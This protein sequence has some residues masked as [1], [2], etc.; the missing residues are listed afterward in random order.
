MKCDCPRMKLIASGF[1]IGTTWISMLTLFQAYNPSGQG[2]SEW[3]LHVSPY[4]TFS[5]RFCDDFLRDPTDPDS[6]RPSDGHP[7]HTPASHTDGRAGQPTPNLR[8]H[9]NVQSHARSA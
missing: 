7:A 2:Q 9:P 8:A 1:S 4:F 5:P 6:D 3:R